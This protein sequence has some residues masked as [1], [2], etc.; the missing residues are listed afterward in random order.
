ML[1][2]Q[3]RRTAAAI[4]TSLVVV[5][6]AGCSEDKK[7]SAPKA[8][9]NAVKVSA[10]DYGYTLDKPMVKSGLTKITFANNGKDAHMMAVASMKAGK[11]LADVTAALNSPDEAAADAVLEDQN[12]DVAPG[13]PNILNPG[14]SVTVYTELPTGKYALICYFPVAGAPPAAGGP[15]PFHYQRGMVNQLEVTSEAS[16]DVAPSTAGEIALADGKLTLPAGFTGKGTF[17]VTNTGPEDHS[18]YFVGLPGGKTLAQVGTTVD[19][20]FEGKA[21]LADLAGV[22]NGGTDSIAAGKSIFV[23]INL[24]PGGYAAICT[25]SNAEGKD[26]TEADPGEAVPF[27]VT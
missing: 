1:S 9:G 2:T 13:L 14:A 7:A 20:Y 6:L 11:T 21:T 19:G 16:T 27:T 4:A 22:L 18:V 12:T 17:R 15:P 25:E 3:V 26:H 5:A 8:F 10:V 24:P 23:E